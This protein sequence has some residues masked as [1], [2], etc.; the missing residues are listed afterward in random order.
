MTRIRSGHVK[1]VCA[2]MTIKICLCRQMYLANSR[3]QY[4]D[5]GPTS[6]SADPTMPG[7]WQG[8]HWSTSC[9][10]TRIR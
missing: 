1:I 3:S 8:S 6:L 9:A 4:A 2:I 5:T 10:L 7:I